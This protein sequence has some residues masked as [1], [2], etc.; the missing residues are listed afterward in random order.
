MS[1]RLFSI[2]RFPEVRR[3]FTVR[4]PFRL[5]KGRQ[6]VG[7]IRKTLAVGTVGVVRPSSKKQRNQKEMIKQ[8][9][10]ANQLAAAQLQ[11]QLQAQAEAQLALAQAQAQTAYLQRQA[12]EA[13]RALAGGPEQL[14]NA[15]QTHAP[16]WYQD[17]FGGTGLRYFDGSAWTDRTATP[18]Q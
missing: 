15:A 7:L 4:S 13:Q 11:A 9:K 3:R 12:A 2:F 14:P 18:Q 6:L 16:G 10:V 5:A 17:P 8:Q 1:E